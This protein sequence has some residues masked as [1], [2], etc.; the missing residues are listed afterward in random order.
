[1]T[2]GRRR[3]L[4]I[5]LHSARNV[6]DAVLLE[7]A[8]QQLRQ[9]F[10]GCHLTLVMND[11]TYRS[12]DPD[13]AVV[14]SLIAAA[15]PYGEGSGDRWRP[16]PLAVSVAVAA[17]DALCVRALGRH[18]P[19][20]GK[21]RAALQR[22][23]A[24]ADLVVS[25]PGNLLFTMGRI[26]L[27]FLFSAF[28]MAQAL[29]L[30]KPLY[31]MPQTVG[32]LTRGRERWLV[33]QL[34][35]RARLVF[36]REP[37]SQRLLLDVGVPAAKVR[38]VPD[39]AF[40]YQSPPDPVG[41]DVIARYGLDAPADGPLLGVT[42]INRIHR[43]VPSEDWD[44]YE[45]TMAVAVSSF[46]ARHGGRA[47]F[48]PQVTGPSRKEDDRI[49]AQRVVAAM[50]GGSERVVIVDEIL[51]AAALRLAYST[52]DLFLATRMHS[53]IFAMAAGVPT[54][55]IEYLGKTTGMMQMAGLEEWVLRLDSLDADALL[56]RLEC[57][58]EQRGEL[59][60]HLASVVPELARRAAG[61]GLAIAED[62]A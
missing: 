55:A 53:A 58:L 3:I 1:M 8:V 33:R 41:S 57:L 44:R 52:M 35:S 26:G 28:A 9:A 49:G 42:V 4:L 54:L 29:A 59:S 27:P 14:P 17:A 7:A 50:P 62:M 19:W 15:R 39:L 10:P 13:V 46:L 60:G 47:V 24:D 51:P 48:F 37:T 12:G 16:L 18:W 61:V 11:P 6:G 25:C 20:P 22:A 5:N 2:D 56:A 36:V 40:A 21:G 23:Y 45:R 30:R 34:L 32:P 43:H 38:L 31:I